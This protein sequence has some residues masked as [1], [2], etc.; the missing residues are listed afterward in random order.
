V[1]GWEQCLCGCWSCV[2]GWGLSMCRLGCEEAA[3]D[4][5][6]SRRGARG[7]RD[8]HTRAAHAK[9]VPAV[10]PL[11][12][13]DDSACHGPL[14][15]S[16]QDH[17]GAGRVQSGGSAGW[18]QGETGPAGQASRTF[19]TTRRSETDRGR[20]RPRGLPPAQIPAS[21]ANALGSCLRFWRRSALADRGAGYGQAAAIER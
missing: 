12:P 20:D 17:T 15:R 10:V 11:R 3:R 13:D 6:D 19:T 8:P 9:R 7:G 18:C 4:V 16:C 1:R 14:H 5:P 2:C 21:A